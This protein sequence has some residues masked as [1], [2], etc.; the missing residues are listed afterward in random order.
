MA[1]DKHI[2]AVCKKEA[3]SRCGKCRA[4]YFCSRACQVAGWP[5]HKPK[6][7]ATPGSGAEAASSKPSST[8][9]PRAYRTTNER[10]SPQFNMNVFTCFPEGISKQEAHE[11][12]IDAFR[13]FCD[14]AYAW[15]GLHYGLYAEEDPFP[16]FEKFI[17]KAKSHLPKW[18]TEADTEAVLKMCRTHPW[19]NIANSV[20]KA[21]INEHYGSGTCAMGMRMWTE[22]FS[23][24]RIGR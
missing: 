13:L 4:V 14:D 18:W 7:K 15:N 8:A 21:D 20:E 1:N 10:P 19:A 24:V 23:G 16:E 17:A 22:K 3:E 12:L 9:G 5:A 6:C 2:C 11:R